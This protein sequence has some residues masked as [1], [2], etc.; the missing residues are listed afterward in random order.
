MNRVQLIEKTV[1]TENALLRIS[2]DLDRNYTHCTGIAFLDNIGTKSSLVSCSVDGRE[3]LPKNMEVLFLQ[4]SSNV[5]P[6]SRFYSLDGVKA[7]G[8]NFQME[9]QDGGGAPS[10]PYTL[11]IYLRLEQ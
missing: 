8:S 4:T 2:E 1:A 10:Y 3:I 6:N 7:G 9:Y 11:K 5:A